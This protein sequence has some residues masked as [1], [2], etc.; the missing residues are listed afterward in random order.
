MG[1]VIA[2]SQVHMLESSPA[3]LPASE[4]GDEKTGSKIAFPAQL[5]TESS[6]TSAS[7]LLY[8]AS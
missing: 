1:E 7:L 8:L 5:S 3:I 6:S 2:T 4:Q